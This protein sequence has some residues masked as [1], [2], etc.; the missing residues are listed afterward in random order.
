MKRLKRLCVGCTRISASPD[1]LSC[2]VRVTGTITHV[3]LDGPM[4]N[5]AALVDLIPEMARAAATGRRMLVENPAEFF[6]FDR[7]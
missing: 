3:N 7:T 1:P 2:R 4:T 5:D 6:G